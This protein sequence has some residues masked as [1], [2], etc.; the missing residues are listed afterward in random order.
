VNINRNWFAFNASSCATPCGTV[1]E[2]QYLLTN[3]TQWLATRTALE[4]D[5]G[6]QCISKDGQVMVALTNDN[7]SSIVM[8]NNSGLTWTELTP[9]QNNGGGSCAMNDNGSVIVTAFANSTMYITTNSGTTWNAVGAVKHWGNIAISS[10]GRIIL[11]CVNA[12][13]LFISHD[14]GQTW[15]GSGPVQD[16]NYAQVSADGKLMTAMYNNNYDFTKPKLYISRDSGLTWT[17]NTAS[18]YYMQFNQVRMSATGNTLVAIAGVFITYPT[19]T[20]ILMSTDFG[21][22]WQIISQVGSYSSIAISGDG[23]NI[24][25]NHEN[26]IFVTFNAGQTW[27]L[28]GGLQRNSQVLNIN[29]VRISDNKSVLMT[30]DGVN[31]MYLIQAK[32]ISATPYHLPS[33]SFD[34]TLSVGSNGLALIE[35]PV[36]TDKTTLMQNGNVYQFCDINSATAKSLIDNSKWT[37]AQPA[38]NKHASSG[39]WQFGSW[40]FCLDSGR[41]STCDKQFQGDICDSGYF[42]TMLQDKICGKYKDNGPYYCTTNA[43]YFSVFSLAATTALAAMAAVSDCDKYFRIGEIFWVENQQTRCAS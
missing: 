12:D 5:W 42:Q 11:G 28:L 4:R 25:V 37:Q 6:L 17:A 7:P 36:G 43:D 8:S 3:S 41:Y 30:V 10:D 32:P 20:R 14:A 13:Q 2:Q 1:N 21:N 15:F 29:R 19:T 26:Q 34:D 33:M 35:C 39:K 24:V 38:V 23:Q 27:N 16:W 31:Y 22:S 40:G 18:E 9:T